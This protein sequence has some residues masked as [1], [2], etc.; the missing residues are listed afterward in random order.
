MPW[1][2][3]QIRSQEGDRP[4]MKLLEP[5]VGCCYN[6]NTF[7]PFLYLYKLATAFGIVLYWV[8]CTLREVFWSI[9]ISIYNM[10]LSSGWPVGP[11]P[12]HLLR[13]KNRRTQIS[14]GWKFQGNTSRWMDGYSMELI[15]HSYSG[16]I[17]IT[18]HSLNYIMIKSL[19]CQD[20]K[21]S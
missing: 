14:E 13:L 20:R 10:A 19:C 21:I 17:Y 8:L 7:A 6:H 5:V 4:M 12:H 1:K 16:W 2:F 15:M 11:A 9:V 3:W 18:W